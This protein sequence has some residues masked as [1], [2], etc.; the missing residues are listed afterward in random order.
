MSSLRCLPRRWMGCCTPVNVLDSA[1]PRSSH[2][3]DCVTLVGTDHAPNK[4]CQQDTAP[5]W[6]I[7]QRSGLLAP[8]I[9]L[10][11]NTSL[12][13]WYFPVKFKHAVVTPLQQPRRQSTEKLSPDLELAVLVQAAGK[14]TVQSCYSATSTPTAL[15]LNISQHIDNYTILKWFKRLSTKCSATFCWRRIKDRCSYSVS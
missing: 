6:P 13:V 5:T 2:C 11:F 9:A 4:S 14:Q 15:C 7:Q 8:L 1:S 12:S 3:E 10:L